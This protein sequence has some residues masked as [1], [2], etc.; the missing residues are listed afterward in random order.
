MALTTPSVLAVVRPLWRP[1]VIGRAV[2]DHE[3]IAFTCQ[4]IDSTEH[5]DDEQQ[6]LTVALALSRVKSRS[7]ALAFV[8]YHGPLRDLGAVIQGEDRFRGVSVLKTP[9]VLREPVADVLS[10]AALLREAFGLHVSAK[11]GGRNSQARAARL[12]GLL[13]AETQG[14]SLWIEAAAA[15]RVRVRLLSPSLRVSC[16]LRVA[17]QLALGIQLGL[18]EQCGQAF[19][20]RDGRQRFCDELCG[21]RARQ[22]RFRKKGGRRGKTTRTR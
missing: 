13:A 8:S 22:E 2:L 5:L 10:A 9:L 4:Q 19:E 16:F 18:C 15:G 20:I 6:S 21:G 7:D 14:A 1:R 17:E 3:Y 11:R 12:A